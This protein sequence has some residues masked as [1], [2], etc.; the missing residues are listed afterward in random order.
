MMAKNDGEAMDTPQVGDAWYV[1][2]DKFFVVESLDD[3][4]ACGRYLPKGGWEIRI[5]YTMY[6]EM[7]VKLME[8]NGTAVSE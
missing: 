3:I 4:G 5:P 1:S 8:R 6:E 7:L 2:T